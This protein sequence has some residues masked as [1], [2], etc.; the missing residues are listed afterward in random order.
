MTRRELSPPTHRPGKHCNQRHLVT[1]A[2]SDATVRDTVM[3]SLWNYTLPCS[4]HSQQ[5]G[6]S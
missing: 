5:I 2:D 4:C 3:V 1:S 6:S